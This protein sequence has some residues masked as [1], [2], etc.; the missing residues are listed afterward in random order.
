MAKDFHM[1]N[2]RLDLPTYPANLP[3]V[4]TLSDPFTPGPSYRG[5]LTAMKDLAETE[6]RDFFTKLRELTDEYAI[7]RIHLEKGSDN[8]S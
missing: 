3:V 8:A 2:V 1:T 5:N 7:N 4:F 6:I